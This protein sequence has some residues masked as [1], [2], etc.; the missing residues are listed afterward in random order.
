MTLEE[1]KEV[2]GLVLANKTRSHVSAAR[3]LA[4][5]VVGLES[6]RI[7][8]SKDETPKPGTDSRESVSR[9]PT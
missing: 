2:A 9:G 1:A 3:E 4:E 7:T 8:L 6:V 5:F